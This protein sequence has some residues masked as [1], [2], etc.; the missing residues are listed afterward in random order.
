MRPLRNRNT[1]PA[2][3]Q[4]GVRQPSHAALEALRSGLRSGRCLQKPNFWASI[5][6]RDWRKGTHH[7]ILSALVE[8]N[9]RLWAS[10][11]PPRFRGFAGMIAVE[12]GVLQERRLPSVPLLCSTRHREKCT[13]LSA[14]PSRPTLSLDVRT[15]DYVDRGGS[16]SL[17]SV[18][19]P[20]QNQ[21][22]RGPPQIHPRA[23]RP[24][25]TGTSWSKKGGAKCGARTHARGSPPTDMSDPFGTPT[26]VPVTLFAEPWP[27][28]PPPQAHRSGSASK[29]AV[30]PRW[31]PRVY[32]L[33][34]RSAAPLHLVQPRACIA[35]MPFAGA[36]VSTLPA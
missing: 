18:P 22:F 26:R 27:P 25:L 11:F 28:A 1:P 31:V 33:Q 15:D 32:A 14:A 10:P 9:I 12:A 23:Q 6:R 7:T 30:P 34:S 16:E 2:A 17:S 21:E 5:N 36:R 29:T 4:R 20:P 19:G 13:R 3:R 24:K 8:P 35:W